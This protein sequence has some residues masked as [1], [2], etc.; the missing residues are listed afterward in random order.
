MQHNTRLPPCKHEVDP[1][2]GEFLDDLIFDDDTRT[3][4]TR[5]H[6]FGYDRA[7]LQKSIQET[8]DRLT[9]ELEKMVVLIPTVPSG[10]MEDDGRFQM[11]HF[12][13]WRMLRK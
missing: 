9:L 12:N 7:P 2:D 8:L 1:F 10:E 11:I 4:M 13:E 6:Y 5:R 3:W